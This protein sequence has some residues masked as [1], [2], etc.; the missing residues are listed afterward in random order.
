MNADLLHEPELD[1]RKAA[2][3]TGFKSAENYREWHAEIMRGDDVKA[4]EVCRTHNRFFTE[5]NP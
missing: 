4:R 5:E 2:A 3:F 1:L